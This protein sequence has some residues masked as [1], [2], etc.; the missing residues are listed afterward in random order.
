VACRL[1]HWT[2]QL[3][4]QTRHLTTRMRVSTSTGFRKAR[5]SSERRK[6]LALDP[7]SLGLTAVSVSTILVYASVG[8]I[9]IGG[10]SIQQ[11]LTRH[12]VAK[13]PTAAVAKQ[14]AKQ[15]PGWGGVREDA[16]PGRQRQHGAGKENAAQ[17]L[18]LTGTT[19][20]IRA[21]RKPMPSDNQRYTSGRR[22][23]TDNTPASARTV[24][25]AHKPSTQ[26]RQRHYFCTLG[27]IGANACGTR[28][29]VTGRSA[30]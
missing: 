2:P 15:R 29:L 11:V 3:V 16:A 17:E 26:T 8:T 13:A 9:P 21:G 30:D 27:V 6:K 5:A 19:L 23:R 10:R 18:T 20:G 14:P 25:C 22:A 24:R 4:G 7:E 1:S 28:R 12:Q